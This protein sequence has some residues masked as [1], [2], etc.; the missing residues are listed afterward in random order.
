MQQHNAT[1]EVE[2][3]EHR[4]RQGDVVR[5]PFRAEVTALVRQLGRP[6]EIIFP[7]DRVDRTDYQL[8]RNLRD[9]LPGHRDPPIVRAVIDHEQLSTIEMTF[10]YNNFNDNNR[11]R[12]DDN[13]CSLIR[14]LFTNK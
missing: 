13:F 1:D 12:E 5:H 9:P 2:S 7:R 10:Y 14:R 3:E 11:R 4:Q 6:Q 8:E